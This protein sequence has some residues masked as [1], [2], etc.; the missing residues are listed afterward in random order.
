MPNI[1]YFFGNADASVSFKDFGK[2]GNTL[3]VG[4]NLLF[5]HDFWLYW[6]SLGESAGD[7]KYGIPLQLSPD[8]N[9]VYSLK[10]GRYN[11]GLEAKNITDALLYDNFSLQKPSRGFYLNLRYFINQNRK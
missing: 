6:P 4:T 2:K 3:N 10:D 8:I 1:P 11:I 9:I 7:S 5:V